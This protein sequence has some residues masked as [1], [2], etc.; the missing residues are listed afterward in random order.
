M[1][2]MEE[3]LNF[4]KIKKGSVL[5]G[6]V[7]S[8]SQDEVV[9]N[10]NYFCDGIIKREELLLDETEKFYE[11]GKEVE[12]YVVSLDDGEGNVILSERKANYFKVIDE[13]EKIY[14]QNNVVSVFV[15]Q[16]L[17]AGLICDF[18]GVEGFIPRS[19]V[20]ISN[21]SLEKF[22]GK[23]LEVKLIEFDVSRNRI[24]FSHRDVEEIRL[25]ENKKNFIDSVSVGDK[26]LATV[27]NIKDFGIFVNVDGVNGFVHKSEMSYKKRFNVDDLVKVSDKIDVYLLK[28]DK[29]NQKIYFTMKDSNFD[30]FSNYSNEF[31]VGE[32]YEVC[33]EKI[34]PS[35]MI[36]YLNDELTGFIHISEFPDSIKNL[37]KEFSFGD[38]I[39]AKILKIDAE[40]KKISLSYSKVFEEYSSS[41]YMEEEKFNTFGEIF[42]DVFSKLK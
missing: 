25:M 37:N 9:V 7:V 14:T 4:N 27:D 31:V 13:L 18:K 42:K 23:S 40:D 38:K 5:K 16:K 10:I 15:K 21:I 32:I 24:I 36:V 11:K 3:S 17:E 22:L 6:K 28:V 39:K 19:K 41:E 1:K 30:V 35:G 34:L 2:L 20:S 26:F 12:V 29:E 8:L 33:V